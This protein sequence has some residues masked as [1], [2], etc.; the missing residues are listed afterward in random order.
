MLF[1][2][3]ART[4]ILFT[5]TGDGLRHDTVKFLFMKCPSTLRDIR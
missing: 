4:P 3:H 1:C 5:L 2:H